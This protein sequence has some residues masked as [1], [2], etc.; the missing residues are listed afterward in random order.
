MVASL[1]KDERGE[2]I[3]LTDSQCDI[4]NIIS[5]RLI[6]RVHIETFTRFGK[7][8]TVALA[9][10]TRVSHFPE[11]WAIG[12]GNDKEA[13]IIM[14]Y[15]ID[16]IFDNDLTR[17]HFLME[18]GESAESIQRHRNRSRIN[19][20]IEKDEKSGKTLLGEL[21]ITNAK[22]AL[23]FGA[24]NVVLDEAALVSDS[25]ESLIFRMIGDQADNFYCKIGN[26]WESGHFTSS[27]KNPDYFKIVVTAEEGLKEGR[28]TQELLDEAKTKP[29]F[30]V[31]YLCERSKT[32]EVED[33][34][35]ISLLSRDEIDRA[36][37][38]DYEPF[39]ITKIGADVAG[40]G[41]NFSVVVERR[42]NVA[43]LRL[44]NQDADTM[45][46]ATWLINRGKEERWNGRDLAIDSVGIGNGIYRLLDL[47][48]AGVQGIDGGAKCPNPQDE[49]LFFN[50]RAMLYWRLREWI[51]KG[52]KL[53][54]T[55]E[56]LENTWYQ[57]AK[58]K[59][60]HRLVGIKTKIQ[61]KTKELMLKDG[62]ESPDVAD[63]LAYTFATTDEVYIDEESGQR[64]EKEVFNPYAIF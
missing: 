36:L 27:F 62:D 44:K 43:R 60:S 64:E 47:N 41:K 11:K 46:L 53:L 51:V 13:A 58:I 20:V 15:V 17:S 24:P 40:G 32:G 9:I 34:K 49:A 55:I 1:Y 2:P 33:G 5:R 6:S 45:N 3:I 28:I 18:K 14:K 38:D 31:L 30:G 10:L 42:T 4:F 7:S 19:F 16:H 29:N 54:K 50:F 26:P 37:I 35:W 12:A 23:G 59:Y 8:L 52:G 25:M 39:G 22:G 57:L 48:L 61:I 63:G 21:F 56:P